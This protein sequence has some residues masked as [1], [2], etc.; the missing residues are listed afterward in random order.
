MPWPDERPD[1]QNPPLHTLSLPDS[2][3][4]EPVPIR[5][6][7]PDLPLL[8]EPLQPRFDCRLTA[9][10]HAH[11]C[12]EQGGA[13]KPSSNSMSISST[14]SSNAATNTIHVSHMHIHGIVS[15]AR[16]MISVTSC[17]A[18]V[19]RYN[20]DPLDWCSRYTNMRKCI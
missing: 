16:Y 1:L 9:S 12:Q 20:P 13:N 19:S 10:I 2:S 8:E 11:P 3:E 14:P 4:S 15:F 17:I 18:S 6:L 5:T 7:T